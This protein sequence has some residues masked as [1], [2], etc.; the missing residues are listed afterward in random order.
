MYYNKTLIFTSVLLFFVPII[1]FLNEINLPQILASDILLIFVS[2]FLILF[3]VVLIS[4]TLHKLLLKN[5]LSFEN[6]FLIN[7]FTLYLLFF[8]QEFKRYIIFI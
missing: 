1:S 8:F 6:F 5:I 2:Q 7:I 4:F 3:V